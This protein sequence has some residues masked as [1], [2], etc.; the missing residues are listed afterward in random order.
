MN[1]AA[2]RRQL[3]TRLNRRLSHTPHKHFFFASVSFF[4]VTRYCGFHFS[5]TKALGLPI[6]STAFPG[7]AATFH[8]LAPFSSL[9]PELMVSPLVWVPF[10]LTF[11]LYTS[12]ALS[13][14]T[15]GPEVFLHN[16]SRTRKPPTNT[17]K[18]MHPS[19]THILL[20]LV[21]PPTK[22]QEKKRE[23][24][25]ENAQKK[26]EQSKGEWKERGEKE[27]KRERKTSRHGRN[28]F[29]APFLFFPLFSRFLFPSLRLPN[30]RTLK[31]SL[32]FFSLKR[33]SPT[34]SFFSFLS[35]C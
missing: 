25:E 19:A 11:S 16:S 21:P 23:K 14:A 13:I 6:R 24:K 7:S 8:N 30:A 15:K 28:G 20:A 3:I 29:D 34:C 31:M 33:A 17:A 9:R 35:P 10:F 4:L 5:Q 22:E 2:L 12:L 18:S 32:L 27:K 26:V 1:A